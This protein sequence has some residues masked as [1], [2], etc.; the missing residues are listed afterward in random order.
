MLRLKRLSSQGSKLVHN[1]L[2]E[3]STGFP[4]RLPPPP[5][6]SPHTPRENILKCLM[7]WGLKEPETH[8]SNKAVVLHYDWLWCWWAWNGAKVSQTADESCRHH[9]CPVM[10]LNNWTTFELYKVFMTSDINFPSSLWFEV[11]LYIILSQNHSLNG[12]LCSHVS[13]LSCR[14]SFTG[15]QYLNWPISSHRCFNSG[16][17]VITHL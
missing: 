3:R 4:L 16:K 13:V 6:S 10:R 2:H 1:A 15:D 12:L 17:F 8:Y 5:A 7:T 14:C 9:E 11:C